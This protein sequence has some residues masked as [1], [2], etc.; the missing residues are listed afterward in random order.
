[1]LQYKLSDHL[2]IPQDNRTADDFSLCF[3]D[4]VLSWGVSM[5]SMVLSFV[6]VIWAQ[7]TQYTF[8]FYRVGTFKAVRIIYCMPLT[9]YTKTIWFFFMAFYGRMGEKS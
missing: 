1:M 6:Y 9:C 4:S 3:E 7:K 5:L 2:S 8:S